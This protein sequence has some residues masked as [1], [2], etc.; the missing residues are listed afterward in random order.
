MAFEP[1]VPTPAPGYQSHSLPRLDPSCYRADAAILWTFTT[2]KRATGWLT[3]TL[4]L[5]FRELLLHM[6]ARHA[7]LCSAYA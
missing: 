2:D 4:H 6:C 3:E 5:K 1:P 7:L